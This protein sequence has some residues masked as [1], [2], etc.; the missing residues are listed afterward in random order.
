MAFYFLDTSALVKRYI[1]ETGTRWIQSLTAPNA[2]NAHF[3]ARITLPE[4]VAAITRRE[5]GGHITPSNAATALTDFQHDFAWQYRIVDISARLIDDAAV[6]A[7]THALRGYDAVQL[8]AALEV[9][10]QIPS[11][12]LVSG[13]GNLNSAAIAEGMAVD[14]PN[15]PP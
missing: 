4:T 14:D 2:S 13:D 5:R 7:R 1:L 9:R 6:L 3:V 10:S 11:L 15:A 12:V 8:A